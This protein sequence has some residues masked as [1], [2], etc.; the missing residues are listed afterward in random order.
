MLLSLS[1]CK[2]I[3][4]PFQNE[5]GD[6]GRP[7]SGDRKNRTGAYMR[8]VGF[9]AKLNGFFRSVWS[10]IW[11]TKELLEHYILQKFNNY[12]FKKSLI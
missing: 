3:Y 12:A 2:K 5:K 4:P 10:T 9:G 6:A 11:G 8:G 1:V 7:K